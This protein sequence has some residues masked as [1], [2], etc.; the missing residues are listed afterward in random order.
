MFGIEK[1]EIPFKNIFKSQSAS[2]IDIVLIQI[3]LS[4]IES[5]PWT[6]SN[7]N[8]SF[9]IN[10]KTRFYKIQKLIYNLHRF[11]TQ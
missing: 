6:I 9:I 8:Y 4:F 5:V 7:K 2:F 1:T 11:A 10:F 3:K